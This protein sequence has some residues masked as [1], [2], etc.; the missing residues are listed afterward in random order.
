MTRMPTKA[1]EGSAVDTTTTKRSGGRKAAAPSAASL[2]MKTKRYIHLG[3]V[4]ARGI[5]KYQRRL[6]R[7][8][9]LRLIREV[10][11]DLR[12][13]KQAFRWQSAAVQAIQEAIEAKVFGIF[14]NLVLAATHDGRDTL[15]VKD[16]EHIKRVTDG[17]MAVRK[18][19]Y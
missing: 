1:E 18:A 5:K 13:D 12:G 16:W 17:C 14:E 6:D 7:L 19:G 9:L 2:K 11:H 10:S 15:E 8:P 4:A 3:T